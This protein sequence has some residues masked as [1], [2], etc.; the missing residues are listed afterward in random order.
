MAAISDKA[1]KSHYAQNKYRYNG[2]ELQNQ[3]FSDGT[4]LEEYDYGARFQDPQLGVWHNID[5][6]ADFMRRFSPYNYAYDNPIRF[7]DPDGMAVTETADGVSYTGDDAAWAFKQIKERYG[8]NNSNDNSSK[9]DEPDKDQACCKVIWDYIKGRIDNFKRNTAIEYG[10]VR[11]AVSTALDN[12]KK[13]VTT[14]NTI[15]QKMF[16][17]FIAN[18]MAFIDGGEEFELMRGALGLAKGAQ[19]IEEMTQLAKEMG[20]LRE[21]SQGR[22]NFGLGEA[23]AAESDRLGKIWVGDNYRIASDGTTLVSADGTHVYRPPSAKNSPFATTGVQSNFEILEKQYLQNGQT[24]M[25][26][27]GNGHVNITP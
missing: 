27:L 18:P 8:N 11:D 1:L 4:G 6:K 22:G 19:G 26:V 14:G 15:P 17:D 13:R 2:K 24:K 23:T 12:A 10:W 9:N 20:L 25:V 3:E 7:I 16:A 21:A 5:P